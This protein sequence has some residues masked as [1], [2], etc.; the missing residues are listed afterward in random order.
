MQTH[1]I[2]GRGSKSRRRSR[3]RICWKTNSNPRC[4]SL[5]FSRQL[6]T[7][8]LPGIEETLVVGDSIIVTVTLMEHP[9][10]SLTAHCDDEVVELDTIKQLGADLE[11]GR[12]YRVIVNDEFIANI[13]VP[14]IDFRYFT[15]VS[16]VEDRVAEQNRR[17]RCAD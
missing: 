14:G 10:S 15:R 16:D 13:T 2:G 11:P 12:T 8:R 7:A 5:T 3:A 4:A 17:T 6:K 1:Q 9:E